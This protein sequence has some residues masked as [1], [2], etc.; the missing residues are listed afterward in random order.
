M[1]DKYKVKKPIKYHNPKSQLNG[2]IVR[3]KDGQELDFPHLSK[4]EIALL[5]RTKTIEKILPKVK[6]A[7]AG[8]E[9]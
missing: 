9:K 2:T 6:P 7:K 3:P 4:A 5:V 1:N 8:K